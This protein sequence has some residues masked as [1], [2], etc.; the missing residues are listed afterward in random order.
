MEDTLCVSHVKNIF[1]ETYNP[2]K[3]TPFQG[4][5]PLKEHLHM[6]TSCPHQPYI[7]PSTP[8]ELSGTFRLLKRTGPCWSPSCVLFLLKSLLGWPQHAWEIS[9]LHLLSHALLI[10]YYLWPC[11]YWD[12]HSSTYSS[13]SPQSID[14]SLLW[15]PTFI[16]DIYLITTFTQMSLKLLKLIISKAKILPFSNFLPPLTF[17]TLKVGAVIY[18]LMPEGPLFTWKDSW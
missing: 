9:S 3:L 12:S 5:M 10:S 4:K 13:Y 15:C 8:L 7:L 6:L 2:L 11:Q 17:P 18:L 16:I 14:A 1:L